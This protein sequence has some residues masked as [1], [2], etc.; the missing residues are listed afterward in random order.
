MMNKLFYD[1]QQVQNFSISLREDDDLIHASMHIDVAKG[2]GYPA[3]GDMV[4]LDSDAEPTQ[5]M[6]LLVKYVGQLCH[7]DHKSTLFLSGIVERIEQSGLEIR[8]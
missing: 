3:V 5:H 8:P 1:W 4:T 6:K 2:A 7:Y